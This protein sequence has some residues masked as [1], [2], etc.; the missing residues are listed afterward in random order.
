MSYKD[1]YASGQQ[2]NKYPFDSAVSF[3]YRNKPDKPKHETNILEIGCGAGNN[4]AF[5]AKEGF[6]VSGNEIDDKAWGAA[7]KKFRDENLFGDIRM[8]SLLECSFP[9]DH[10]DLVIDRAALSYIGSIGAVTALAQV[11]RVLKTGG[12]FQSEL[13]SKQPPTGPK[14]SHLYN[15]KEIRELFK[16]LS[17]LDIK[18][19]EVE[20]VFP[21]IH[22]EYGVY[23]V[24]AQKV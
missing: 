20:T 16:D 15:I 17:I 3:I 8:E 13:Y 19:T 7:K 10:Y 2:F 12:K 11:K 22:T 14:C 21:N 9:S 23:K 4:L 1:I 5:A 18:H 6:N 24:L